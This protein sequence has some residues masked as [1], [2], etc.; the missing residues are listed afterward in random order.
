MSGSKPG[1]ARATVQRAIPQGEK[2]WAALSSLIDQAL[3]QAR[4]SSEYGQLADD[5]RGYAD[6]VED[7]VPMNAEDQFVDAG[8]RAREMSKGRQR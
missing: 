8:I 7:S 5:L 2:I 1:I 4:D 3:D 6:D